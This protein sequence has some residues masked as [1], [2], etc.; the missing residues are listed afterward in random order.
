MRLLMREGREVYCVNV[1]A[2]PRDNACVYIQHLD[3]CMPYDI[4]TFSGKS[5]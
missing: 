1:C 3:Q 2:K 5:M 4:D